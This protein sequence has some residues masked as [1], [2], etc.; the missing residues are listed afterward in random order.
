MYY[1]LKPQIMTAKKTSL[2]IMKFS[3]YEIN[4]DKC[5]IELKNEL[6]SFSINSFALVPVS[7]F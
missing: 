2:T 1:A 7:G 4:G 3:I 6:D 5:P